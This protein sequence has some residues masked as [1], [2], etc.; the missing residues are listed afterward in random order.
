MRESQL[1][2]GVDQPATYQIKVQ[3]RLEENWSDWLGGMS[4][5]FEG[6]VSGPPVTVLT[7]IVSDQAALHGLLNR[8]RDLGL[9][10]LDV[11]WI[12]SPR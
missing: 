6:Q 10:L 7:G 9:P 4:I 12:D 1:G 5:T 8:V 11:H 3:G 2:L